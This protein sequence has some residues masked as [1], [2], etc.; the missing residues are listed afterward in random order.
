VA[1]SAGKHGEGITGRKRASRHG[2]GPGIGAP[3]GHLYNVPLER[4]AQIL[5]QYWQSLIVEFVPK[6]RLTSQRLLA[7]REIFLLGLHRDGFEKSFT[8]YFA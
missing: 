1:A 8:E 2:H 6:T 3:P 7:S 4:I 5:Q